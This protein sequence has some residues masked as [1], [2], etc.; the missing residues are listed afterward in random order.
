MVKKKQSHSLT[1]QQ[2]ANVQLIPELLNAPRPYDAVYGSFREWNA[3]RPTGK[4][5]NDA[6]AEVEFTGI[7]LA[8][9]VKTIHENHGFYPVNRV[10]TTQALG[11][12]HELG[13]RTSTVLFLNE[14][15]RRQAK[16]G[17]DIISPQR[18]SLNAVREFGNHASD[19]RLTRIV[20]KDLLE[21]T[22]TINPNLK[23]IDVTDDVPTELMIP[24]LR[25]HKIWK[26]VKTA[27]FIPEQYED[28]GDSMDFDYM[29]APLEGAFEEEVMDFSSRMTVMGTR[30]AA[31]RIDL[32]QAYRERF[33]GARINEANGHFPSRPAVKM[34][35][36]VAARG[37]YPDPANPLQQ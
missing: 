31:D 8:E 1:G 23:M 35:L 3:S 17:T 21:R 11:L 29:A 34:V 2:G 4:G 19:A 28:M 26:A 14:K 37:F 30:T 25:N 15:L 22:A 20:L 27:R 12:M 5:E 36:G 10:E 18:T 13:K 33:W 7:S 32:Q 6:P 24:V 16:P 9:R